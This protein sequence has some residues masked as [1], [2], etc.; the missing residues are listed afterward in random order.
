MPDAL[1]LLVVCAEAKLSLNQSIGEVSQQLRLSNKDVADE[2]SLTSAEMQLLP[3]FVQ[4]LDNLVGRTGLDELRSLVATLKQTLKFGTPLAES[5]RIIAG[6]MRATH[7]ARIEERAAR[8]PVLLASPMMVF[9]LPSLLMVVG[10]PLAL[11]MIDLFSN[12][13]IRMPF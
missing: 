12:L 5:L 11:R 8:L 3:D 1:D 10:T 2:F 6:E 7:H 9:F 4:A 13:T